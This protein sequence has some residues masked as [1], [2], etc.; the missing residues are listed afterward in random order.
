ML[1][2]STVEFRF[3]YFIGNIWKFIEFPS[4]DGEP[5]IYHPHF[6]IDLKGVPS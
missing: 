3:K 6:Y 1:V 2:N 4:Y 5:E